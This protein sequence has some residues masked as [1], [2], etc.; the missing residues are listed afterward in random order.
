MFVSIAVL[1]FWHLLSIFQAKLLSTT[2]CV[3]RIWTLSDVDKN[4]DLLNKWWKVL[5]FLK[6][7]RLPIQL[8][9]K[10]IVYFCLDKWSEHSCRFFFC[11]ITFL[12][13]CFT[14]SRSAPSEAQS[15]FPLWPNPTLTWYLTTTNEKH[16]RQVLNVMCH[17]SHCLANLECLVCSLAVLILSHN[18]KNATHK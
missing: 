7:K 15:N 14:F 1:L 6:K 10:K 12:T 17:L 2:A 8:L 13:N 5:C 9:K 18:T 4:G 16:S 3:V 11:C